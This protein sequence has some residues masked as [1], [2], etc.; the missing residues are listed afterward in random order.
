MGIFYTLSKAGWFLAA[1][2]NFCVFLLVLAV[3]ALLLRLRRTGLVFAVLATAGLMGFGFSPAGNY[4]MS[5]LEERFPPF[6]DDG[7]PVDGIIM[8]GGA[9]VPEVSVVR[10]V[11]ALNDAAERV[12]AFAALARRYPQAKLVF[13]GGSGEYNESMPAAQDAVRLAFADVGLDVTRVIYERRSR[14]TA[15]N[16]V[17]TRKLITPVPDERWLLVTSA[18]HMPRAI[19]CFREVGFPVTAYP[20]DYRTLGPGRLNGV[21]R[22]V[23]SGLDITDIAVREW[24]GL[25]AYYA[26]GRIPAL[27]PAPEPAAR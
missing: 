1:P 2:S 21:F 6:V 5:P 24:M 14:N 19:G 22:R 25:G 10:G 4:L 17:E 11:T 9:E 15:Q 18:F 13:S 12:L 23:A 27:F 3:A 20:V 26:S 16:A 8:L 7:R